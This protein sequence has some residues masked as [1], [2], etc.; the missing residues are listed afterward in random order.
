MSNLNVFTQIVARFKKKIRSRFNFTLP[1]AFSF[2]FPT[3]D[4]ILPTSEEFESLVPV[5]DGSKCVMPVNGGGV[6]SLSRYATQY[7]TVSAS[8]VILYQCG[9]ILIIAVWLH[10]YTCLCVKLFWGVL[11]NVCLK[12][13]AS[14]CTCCDSCLL[15]LSSVDVRFVRQQY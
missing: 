7:F 15:T 1:G 12:L 8:M 2:P 13:V 5:A 11:V 3:F 10:G 9:N 6:L 4:H 14:C